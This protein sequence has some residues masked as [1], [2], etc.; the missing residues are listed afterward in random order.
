MATN[1]GL[2]MLLPIPSQSWEDS[3]MD[4][5]LG[6]PRTQRVVHSVTPKGP[7]DLLPVSDK[8]RVHGK[9]VDFIHGLQEIHEAMLNNLEKAVR[10]YKTAADR[11]RS[12]MEFEVGNFVWAV[13]TNDRF[14]VGDYQKFA[15]RKI[16]PVE[17]VE[18]INPNA[19]RLKLPNHIRTADVFNVK[20][21]IPYVG[22]SL[23]D[24]DL[25]A[26]SLHQGRMMRQKTW[27]FGTSRKI[28]SDDPVSRETPSGE[29]LTHLAVKR[30]DLGRILSFRASNGCF[31]VIWAFL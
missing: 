26:N 2:Y 17:V 4:F 10:K 6:L 7:L 21:L 23:N 28:G 8:I 25:R 20:H 22:D 18:K 3:N 9:A 12:H 11:K 16:G 30:R 24:D 14:S 13:L 5:V 1:A 31:Y 29:Q 19:Y 15:A 27:Q